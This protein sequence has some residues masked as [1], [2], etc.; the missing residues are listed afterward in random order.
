MSF[1]FITSVY[2]MPAVSE[3]QRSRV[4][5]SFKSEQQSTIIGLL[6]KHFAIEI[7]KPRFKSEL[8]TQF[9][10]VSRIYINDEAI[11]IKDITENLC[12]EK[13]TEDLK[14]V[15]LKTTKRRRKVNKKV[16]EIDFL[17]D[18]MFLKGY[19]FIPHSCKGINY[20]CVMVNS[21]VIM[22]KA[23]IMKVGD[24]IS[25]FISY[26]FNINPSNKSIVIPSNHA[27]IRDIMNKYH[28]NV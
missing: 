6:N 23:T 14:E 28:C 7:K 4:K 5:G 3:Q 26:L 16:K 15:S 24:E 8:S 22:N 1:N 21:K 10:H 18:I 13:F 12:D 20:E 2:Y 11:N 25:N 19:Y 27:A 9:Y 17:T